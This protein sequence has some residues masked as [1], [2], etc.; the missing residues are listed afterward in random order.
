[1]S[2]AAVT[3]AGGRLDLVKKEG[4]LGIASGST[5][6]DSQSHCWSPTCVDE[7]INLEFDHGTR[8]TCS[9]MIDLREMKSQRSFR[10]MRPGLRDLVFETWFSRPGFRDAITRL[11]PPRFCKLK[12]SHPAVMTPAP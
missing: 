4:E 3:S 1:M 2:L 12:F 11:D 9:T 10:F 5:Q 7:D 8:T 6:F